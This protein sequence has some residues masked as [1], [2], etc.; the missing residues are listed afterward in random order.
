MGAGEGPVKKP[1]RASLR[2]LGSVGEPINPEEWEWYPPCG[3]GT[4]AAR[5]STLGGRRRPAAF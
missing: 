2:L 3:R 1:S 5:L 4:T